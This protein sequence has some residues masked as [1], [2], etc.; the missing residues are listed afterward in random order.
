[1]KQANLFE[2]LHITHP[3][4]QAPMAGGISTSELTAAVSNHGGLGMI[5][6]GY[7]TP[8]ELLQQIKEVKQNTSNWFGVNIFVPSEYEVEDCALHT[9][10]TLL[11]PIRES[12][13]L[14]Q[15][16]P[17]LPQ[18]N[19][20]LANYHKLIDLLIEERIPVCSFTFGIPSKEI[21]QRLK[22][23]NIVLIGTATTVKE[24]IEIERIGL[25][26]VVL[27]GS[28]AGG[29]R[30]T[31]LHAEEEGLV[32]LMSLIP[33]TVKLINIPIIAS[34]GIMDG[35][36]LMAARCLGA[37]AVQMGT[38][39]L[40]CEESGASDIHKQAV[41]K[42]TDSQTTLTR[43]FSGK[44]ARAINNTFIR[45]MQ[46]REKD[47]PAF[48]IQNTLTKPIRTVS[49]QQNNREYMSLWSGQSPMLASIQTA[50]ELIDRVMQEAEEIWN[51]V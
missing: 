3:I 29:H 15:S 8:A 37:A 51:G 21:I 31:F 36:G 30:A 14:Q 26:I 19:R 48:P 33:Q 45:L 5:A 11:E 1:M 4:I 25:D 20:D 16:E 40:T 12:L 50:E 13:H 17:T 6:A 18:A 9:S 32:G 38:A 2:R 24:A 7:L 28:E 22:K 27:Q 47:L 23:H 41:T 10:R 43:T 49:S 39:F 44:K 42:A 35:R 46:S 34:G